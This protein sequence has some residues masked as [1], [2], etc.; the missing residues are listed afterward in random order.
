MVRSPCIRLCVIDPATG[1]CEG[2][3][4]TLDEITAWP[5]L[6]D[7]ERLAL[8]DRLATRGAAAAVLPR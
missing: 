6:T 7:E 3:R 8:L 5:R 1:L 4:R 2:C